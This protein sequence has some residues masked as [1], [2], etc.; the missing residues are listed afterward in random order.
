M[1][2]RSKD[3]KVAASFTEGGA[4][5]IANSFGLPAG[6]KYA[7]PMAT[8]VCSKVCYAGK[9]EKIRPTVKNAL[10]HNWDMLNGASE[11]GMVD[12]LDAMVAQFEAECDKWQAP[13]LF[14]IHWDGD[15]FSP[16]YTRAW[17][18]VIRNHPGTKFWVYTRV[19]SAALTLKDLQNLA[20]YFSADEDNKKFVPGMREAGIRIAGLGKTF[21]D[22]KAIV[23]GPA[24]ICPE[25]TGKVAL[26]GACV[27]CGLCV[28]GNIDIRF[29]ISKK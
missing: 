4:V 12:L 27:S 7:C 9:L 29:S 1:L 19:P 10:L 5:R 22:A 28:A 20:L 26:N 18:S 3:R 16:D 21:A 25:Q 6:I 23:G 13:K 11:A 15:F 8:S 24:G 2:K 14:R 17:G